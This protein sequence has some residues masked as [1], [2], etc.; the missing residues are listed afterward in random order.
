MYSINPIIAELEEIAPDLA[1]TRAALPFQ[2]P[3][4]N[5]ETLDHLILVQDPPF[6]MDSQLPFQTPAGY[7]EANPEKLMSRI[8]AEMNHTSVLGATETT[9]QLAP[10]FQMRKAS[11]WMMY[12]AAA[13]LTGL[14]VTGA[15]LFS[16]KPVEKWKAQYQLEDLGATLDGVPDA[17]LEQ[18]LAENQ[19]I[20][21]EEVL[22]MNNQKLPE[23]ANHIQGLSNEN[24]ND[25][26]EENSHL[27][28][29][30]A[31]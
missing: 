10:L 31:E 2:A 20:A 12:A 28:S 7:F 15:F 23:L 14:L 5:F 1:N 19:P 4:G 24:L 17:D 18:Y 21:V 6:L 30:I 26:L 25:Y 9:Q 29:A 11:K 3:K 27:E 16:D 13:M 22:S 8:N